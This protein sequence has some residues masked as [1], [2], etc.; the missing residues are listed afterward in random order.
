M[1]FPKNGVFPTWFS[2]DGFLPPVS[3][4]PLVGDSGFSGILELEMDLPPLPLLL[5]DFSWF[6]LLV[7]AS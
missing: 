3:P 5:P 4:L 1:A 7:F 2:P 6:L